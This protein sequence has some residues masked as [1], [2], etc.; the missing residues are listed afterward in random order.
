VKEI[1]EDIAG[2]GRDEKDGK[3][4]QQGEDDDV[5]ARTLVEGDSEP[6]KVK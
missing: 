2:G 1:S 4:L 5:D 3:K 6:E